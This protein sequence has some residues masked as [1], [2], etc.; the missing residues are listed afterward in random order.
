MPIGPKARNLNFEAPGIGNQLQH[1][2]DT[3]I[4]SG[5]DA[6]DNWPS[7]P[8]W[9]DDTA[10]LEAR[11]R[12]YLDIN[13]AHC[14]RSTG[15]ASN[16]GLFLTYDEKNRSSWGYK[17]RP[18][19]AGNGTGGHQFAIAPGNAD[20]SILVH[21]MRSLKTGVMMPELGRST[22][23]DEAIKLISA[24]INSLD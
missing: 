2:L 19:A 23:D 18:V 5:T 22:A 14:H 8:D 15:P 24:W 20:Q 10:T 3:A 21:R 16:S 17:K 11:A 7:V 4:L 13:C 12:A 6:A 9:K 1:W